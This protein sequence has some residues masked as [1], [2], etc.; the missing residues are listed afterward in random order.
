MDKESNTI[1]NEK[2]RNKVYRFGKVWTI[3][4]NQPNKINM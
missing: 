3:T 1:E 4:M 2:E